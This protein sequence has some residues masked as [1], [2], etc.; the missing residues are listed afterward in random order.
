MKFKC[1]EE[2]SNQR[3]K[4]RDCCV[5]V[6]TVPRVQT[7][8]S[9]ANPYIDPMQKEREGIHVHLHGPRD[10]TCRYRLNEN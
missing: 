9:R 3:N 5:M 2:V 1:G 7:I 10:Y 4:C 6:D 8:V